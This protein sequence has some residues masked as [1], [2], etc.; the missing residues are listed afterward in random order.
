MRSK[1]GPAL[2]P[3]FPAE[4]DTNIVQE[5][6]TQQTIPDDALLKFD[7]LAEDFVTGVFRGVV[8]IVLSRAHPQ[9]GEERSQ[10][11]VDDIHYVI[12]N[13]FR[14]SISGAN[15]PIPGI[16]MHTSTNESNEKLHTVHEC[17]SHCDDQPICKGTVCIHD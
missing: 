13:H 17:S 6:Y 15:Q 4:F 3:F 11:T 8:Q 5:V 7:Q 16:I 10:I 2:Q 9:S 1:G 14:I 12:Q